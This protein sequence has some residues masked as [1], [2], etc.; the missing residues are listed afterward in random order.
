MR[1]LGLDISTSIVGVSFVSGTSSEVTIERLS[2]I[3][4]NKCVDIWQKVD[5]FTERL[6]EEFAVCG[7]PDV[8]YVEEAL[9]SFRPGLSNAQTI[10]TLIKFNALCSMVVR[11]V[12]GVPPE[13]VASTTARKSCG[14]KTQQVKKIGIP[15]KQ[16]VF[17]WARTGPLKD[18]EFELTRT[19]SFKPWNYDE[20]DAYVIAR[21]GLVLES[22][23]LVTSVQ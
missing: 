17:E 22:L 23:K 9:L 15:V 6:T 8:V 21:A 19:G 1:V 2:H 14:I 16:Q 12:M 3:D 4:F 20:V 7:R 5:R 13:F 18:R 11:S 10:T